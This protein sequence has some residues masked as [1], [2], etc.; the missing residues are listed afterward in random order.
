MAYVRH[1][2]IARIR[3]M[4]RHRWPIGLAT[5][6]ALLA[7]PGAADAGCA[8][9]GI[10]QVDLLR[11]G[12]ITALSPV[13]PAVATLFAGGPSD[14]SLSPVIGL[15]A[16]MFTSGGAF[17]HEA[18]D[19]AP[20]TP[21]V[22][23]Q[24]TS[25]IDVLHVAKEAG[26]I[27]L[28]FDRDD[29]REIVL[30]PPGGGAML[31]GA[32]TGLVLMADGTVW[33]WGVDGNFHLGQG[34]AVPTEIHSPVQVH[35]P[36]N[37]GFF[38]HVTAVAS[39]EPMSVALESD[40]TVWSWGDN[41]FF[42]ELGIGSQNPP[43]SNVPIQV[44]GTGGPGTCL[45]SIVAIG[46]RGYHALALA[47]DGTVYAWGMNANGECGDGSTANAQPT[48]VQVQGLPPSPILAVNGGFQ[49]S[50][51]LDADGIV[52]GWGA[53]NKGQM[54]DGTFTTPRLAP[55]QVGQAI[56]LDGIT[57][58]SAGWKHALALR[59]DGTVWA[60]GQ[61]GYGEI[62][63]GTLADAPTPL[64]V[65]GPGGVGVLSGI[66]MVSAGDCHSAALRAD[67]TV[68]TW[69]CNHHNG[70]VPPPNGSDPVGQLGNG[71]DTYADQ[72]FPVQ[73]VGGEQGGQYL[74]SITM[75]AARD[76]HDYALA[77]DGTLYSWGSNLNGQLGNGTCCL[78]STVPVVVTFP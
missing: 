49:Y 76:Y 19:L 18:S 30:P 63:D 74:Q 69:G 7:A 68:W 15:E 46:S 27:A 37:V 62:G 2:A 53:N 50:L 65:R 42:G 22:F 77:A 61:N 4:K 14:P 35:G 55:Q 72:L 38:D 8:G 1:G 64:E 47:S 24:L 12:D 23:Y 67:G 66:V 43:S 25:P 29:R 57:Q 48:P 56:G 40:G 75:V 3:D 60:W 73:V 39:G 28:T 16:P 52:W 26:R 33:N 59:S 70:F 34:N 9:A 20:G 5:G 36:G 44:V 71:D 51:A 11:N 13:T 45:P 41:G 54:G 10:E 21:L 32:R 31:G 58:V 17:P 78:P 6:L